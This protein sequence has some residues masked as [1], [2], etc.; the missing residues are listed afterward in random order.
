MCD[1]AND[2]ERCRYGDDARREAA[3]SYLTDTTLSIREVTYLLGFSE[4]T[5]FHRAF[6]RWH[7]TTPQAF[8]A[9]KRRRHE[10]DA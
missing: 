3:G 7:G 2:T 6:K 5:S 4:P 10:R 8:R 9:R 1:V